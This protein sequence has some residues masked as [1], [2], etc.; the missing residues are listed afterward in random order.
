VAD[1]RQYQ[2]G[3]TATILI[4]HPYQGPVQALITVERGHIYDYWVQTLETNSEQIEIPITEDLI[5]NVFVSVV[6]VSPPSFPPIG[7]DERGGVDVTLGDLVTLSGFGVGA[8]MARPGETLTVTLVWR[9]E[10]ETRISYHVFLHLIGPD[11]ALVAQSDGIPANWTRPTTGW[12]PGEYITDAHI[13]TIPPDAPAGD[14]TLYAG[15]YVPGGKRLTAP[16]G[17]DAIHLTTI[18]VQA[19]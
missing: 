17:S 4:P 13:L 2:V 18:T 5:P 9:A 8:E 3:D 15:L 12:L 7:G 1:Q 16:D 6:I 11:G 14:Y 10:A 19:Q